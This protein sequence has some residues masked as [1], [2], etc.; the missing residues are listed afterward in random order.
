MLFRS[1]ELLVENQAEKLRLI[2]EIKSILAPL[3]FAE[4]DDGPVKIAELRDTLW[5]TGGYLGYGEKEA[6]QQ[7]P[8]IAR[9]LGSLQ[10][11]TARLQK[12][13]SRGEAKEQ[14]ALAVKLGM[15]QH[16]LFD[17][18]RD[19]FETLRDQ[20]NRERLRVED[21][22]EL[23]RHRFVGAGGKQLLQVYPKKNAWQRANQEE[24]IR[25]LRAALEK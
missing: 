16:E 3:H 9:Q 23:L 5:A 2:G 15:F 4:P 7:D 21:L 10:D 24:F 22:P 17:D 6:G 11:A 12:E 14:Q 8:A 20:N 25:E 19:T 13:L 1:A 18:L